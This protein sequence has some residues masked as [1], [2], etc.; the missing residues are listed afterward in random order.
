MTFP[1]V[2][3]FDDNLKKQ[4]LVLIINIYNNSG[5]SNELLFYLITDNK[6]DF[7]FE[8]EYLI[9]ESIDFKLIRIDERLLVA[10]FVNHVTHISVATYY[11]LLALDIISR[12]HDYLLIHD[13]DIY[14]NADIRS[15]F[16]FKSDEKSLSVVDRGEDDYFG[17]GFFIINT[18][19]ARNKFTI[20]NFVRAYHDNKD[21]I[22][23]NEQDLL[24]IVFKD[25]YS[26]CIP[27]L[28]DFPVQSYLIN[29]KSFHN[30]GLFLTDAKS[31]HY[32]G[33]TKPWRHS[34][35]LPFARKWR[36]V[37][38]EIYRKKAWDRITIKD[39]F[40]DLILGIS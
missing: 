3:V 25:D 22:K 38:F 18:N 31:I 11:K 24:N 16:K 29:Q 2:L 40:K 20:D 15:V 37:Y 6:T 5:R 21:Y 36:E 17:A 12:Q 10:N 7:S 32:P 8:N 19:R 27:Y 34:T 30:R 26:M 4:A 9:K 13:I 14:N 35:V 28:W 39:F 33:T 1:I 23:W